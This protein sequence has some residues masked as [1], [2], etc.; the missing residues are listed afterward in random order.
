MVFQRG[1]LAV[2][3]AMISVMMRMEGL[4]GKI[5]L[6]WAM[7]S[8]KISFWIVPPILSAG[9]PC[10][11]ATTMYMARRIPAGPLMVMEV[12]TLSKGM[13]SKMTSISR[14]LSTA[15]PHRPTSPKERG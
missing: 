2:Q 10:F 4:G 8:F 1:T 9:I 14:R 15:T 5:Q 6:F 13:P 11:S 12:V 7:Y 3:Y